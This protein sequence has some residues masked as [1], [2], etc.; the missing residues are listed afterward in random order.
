MTQGLIALTAISVFLSVMDSVNNTAFVTGFQ[1]TGFLLWASEQFFFFYRHN[2]N[3]QRL[4]HRVTEREVEAEISE[5][6]FGKKVIIRAAVKLVCC[7]FPSNYISTRIAD[8]NISSVF[9][10]AAPFDLMSMKHTT[11]ATLRCSCTQK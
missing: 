11:L 3:N 7:H 1:F 6:W 5:R 9:K 4:Q 10:T 2:N 8:N